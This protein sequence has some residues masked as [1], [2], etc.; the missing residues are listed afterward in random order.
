MDYLARTYFHVLLHIL[1]DIA[2]TEIQSD[3]DLI[4]IIVAMFKDNNYYTR[5][6]GIFGMIH[7]NSL[8]EMRRYDSRDRDSNKT[9]YVQA[10]RTHQS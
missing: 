1:T 7:D 9:R 6:P 10:R 5:R 3:Y 8:I 2:T 4:G